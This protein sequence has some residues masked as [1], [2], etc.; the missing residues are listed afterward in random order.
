M[1]LMFFCAC[2]SASVNVLICA[3]SIAIRWLISFAFSVV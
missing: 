1:A 3:C 2:C